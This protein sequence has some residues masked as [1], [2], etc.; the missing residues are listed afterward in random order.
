MRAVN[1]SESVRIISIGNPRLSIQ[2]IEQAK[3]TAF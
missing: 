2:M 3:D 1:A